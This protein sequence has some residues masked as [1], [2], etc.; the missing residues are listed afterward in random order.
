MKFKSIQVYVCLVA[1]AFVL[2]SGLFGQAASSTVIGTVTDTTGS[3]IPEATV[4]GLA[5]TKARDF[6][7]RSHQSERTIRRGVFPGW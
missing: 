1:M 4:T 3:V 6:S 5:R 2:A 7:D